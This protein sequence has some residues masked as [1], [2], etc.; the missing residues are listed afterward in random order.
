MQRINDACAYQ[1]FNFNIDMKTWTCTKMIKTSKQ[2]HSNSFI[3]SERKFLSENTF[4]TSNFYSL[5]KIHKSEVIVAA[6]LSQNIV[7]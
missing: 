4:G 7:I 1:K 2:I 3:E 5:P 6:I